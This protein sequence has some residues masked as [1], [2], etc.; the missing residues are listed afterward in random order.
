M[1]GRYLHAMT[2]AP[3]ADHAVTGSE[4]YFRERL[5]PSP[6]W[7]LA[8]VAFVAMIAIA[9]GAALGSVIGWVVG[10]GL[11][12]LAGFTIWRSSPVV[13]IDDHG[14]HAG[15]A[16]LPPGCSRDS[17]VIT[18]HEHTLV[19]R[20]LDPE[21]GDSAFVLQP[22]WIPQRAVV[23]TLCDPTDPHSSWVVGSRRP[24]QLKSAWDRLPR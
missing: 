1:H 6:G 16:L 5:W 9:Y 24:E 22:P 8:I 10:G 4:S 17:R 20:G 18:G 7:I 2:S 11:L 21:V 15:P 19:R 14:L 3:D 12:L 13:V 23:F